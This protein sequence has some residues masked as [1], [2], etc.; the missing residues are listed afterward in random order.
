MWLGFQEQV[1]TATV[2][3]IENI[4]T[5]AQQSC[6]VQCGWNSFVSGGQWGQNDI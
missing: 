1:V 5:I 2:A 4:H 3:K 6:A